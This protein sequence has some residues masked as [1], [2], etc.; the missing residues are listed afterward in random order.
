M[1]FVLYCIGNV[2]GNSSSFT[3]FSVALERQLHRVFNSQQL[4]DGVWLLTAPQLPFQVAY[5][6]LQPYRS[7]IPLTPNVRSIHIDEDNWI[8]RPTLLLNRLTALAGHARRVYARDTVAARIDKPAAIAFLREHHLQVALPGKYRLGL[9]HQGELVAVAV[10]SGGRRMRDKPA[11][12]RS[13]EL[14][15]FCHKQGTHVI[16]GFSKLLNAFNRLFHP[17]DVMTYADKDWT[18]GSTYQQIGFTET[19]ETAP[20]LFWVDCHTFVR[21]HERTLPAPFNEK[22]A[23]QRQQDGFIPVYNSGGIKMVKL[24]D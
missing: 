11:G 22:T 20:Q 1:I 8:T 21:Y 3:A 6:A 19:G 15:R 2:A 10:F 17:G 24:F 9:F 4:A 7:R 5:Y 23:V 13:F 16:G 12:Y 14:L 18:N